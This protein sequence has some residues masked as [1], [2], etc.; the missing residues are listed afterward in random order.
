MTWLTNRM[1]SIGA[2]DKICMCIRCIIEHKS[3]TPTRNVLKRDDLFIELDY[4]VRDLSQECRLKSRPSSTNCSP[5]V[6]IG[7]FGVLG[8]AEDFTIISISVVMSVG[9]PVKCCKVICSN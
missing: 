9:I 3:Y 8:N 4:V 2:H 1:Y 6:G 7:I 5:L